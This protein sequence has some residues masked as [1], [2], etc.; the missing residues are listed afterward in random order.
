LAKAW[1]EVSTPERTINVPIKDN[2]AGHSGIRLFLTVL[3]PGD[4]PDAYDLMDRE[5]AQGRQVYIILPLVEESE[6]LDLKSATEEYK[7]LSETVF[8]QYSLGLLHGRMSSQD[9]DAALTAFRDRH[10]QILVSTT[11]V[12]VGVDVPNAT[13][14]MIEHADRFG[15]SQLH[16]LRGRVG[17]GSSSS[18]CLLV[19]SGKGEIARQR[20]E[21]MAQSQDGF[22]IAEM[23]LRFRGP[24]EVLGK[25]QSGLPDLA[26]ASLIED[27]DVLDQARTTAEELV[28][29]DPDL[30]NYP[31]IAAELKTRYR[32]LLGGAILT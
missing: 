2:L 3:K 1:T 27:R 20:L 9:K 26:L 28:M 17:R 18:Y 10:T 16:Q 19:N 23:D 25:R 8:P 30:T 11:V 12:E 4:R 6:K 15:L 32:R 22:F 24:G 21:V 7:K 5:I 13:V 14:M 31:R 29:E